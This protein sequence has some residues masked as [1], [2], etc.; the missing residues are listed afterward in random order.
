MAKYF[1]TCLY[2]KPLCP[3]VFP[4]GAIDRVSQ[5][6]SK[7]SGFRGS[8]A[9]QVTTESSGG[10]HGGVGSSATSGSPAHGTVPCP[11]G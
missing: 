2:F 6:L 11:P 1:A 3:S 5:A 4:Q 7:L 10:L 8:L 9:V